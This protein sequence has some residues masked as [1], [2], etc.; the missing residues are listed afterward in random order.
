MQQQSTSR[1]GFTNNRKERQREM[2]VD[3]TEG[4]LTSIQETRILAALLAL[5]QDDRDSILELSHDD[6]VAGF[7]KMVNKKRKDVKYNV[8][9][10]H[11][12]ICGGTSSSE[13]DGSDNVP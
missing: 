10:K 1:R 12:R 7:K 5:S 11:K 8:S 13:L 9:P 6:L 4:S 2:D 3:Q